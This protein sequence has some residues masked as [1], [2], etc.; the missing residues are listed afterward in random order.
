[1]SGA[2]GVECPEDEVMTAL[3]R[4]SRG[5]Q[6]ALEPFGS[7]SLWFFVAAVYDRRLLIQ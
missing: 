1:M 4:N 5:Q 6:P 7:G 2:K 3:L